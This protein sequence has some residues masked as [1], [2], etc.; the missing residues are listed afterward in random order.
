MYV[1]E[2]GKTELLETNW[3]STL[4]CDPLTLGFQL[5]FNIQISTG[6]KIWRKSVEAAADS[7]RVHLAQLYFP[8]VLLK[9]PE[10]FTGSQVAS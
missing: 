9:E 5:Q 10:S 3:T 2:W 8:L 7:F 6:V 4:P 1:W